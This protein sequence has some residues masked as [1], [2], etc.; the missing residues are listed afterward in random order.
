MT[1]KEH[2]GMGFEPKQTGTIMFV[3]GLGTYMSEIFLVGVVQNKLGI[4]LS[5]YGWSLLQMFLIPSIVF[6]K[7]IGSDIW[8]SVICTLLFAIIKTGDSGC[9]TSSYTMLRESLLD[10]KDDLHLALV[11][12]NC[13][14]RLIEISHPLR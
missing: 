10:D 9:W 2:H 6:W 8:F 1:P 12:E 4:K 14:R 5:F 7:N 3:A 11:W 13:I